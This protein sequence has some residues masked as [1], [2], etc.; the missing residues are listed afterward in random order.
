MSF[1]RYPGGKS[2]LKKE[3]VGSLTF[4][5]K[6]YLTRYCEPFWG[7]GS[8]GMAFIFA[9][10]DISNVWINDKDI[11][12]ASLWTAV[13]RYSKDLEKLVREFKPSIDKFYEFKKILLEIS[14]MPTNPKEIL[15]IGFQKLAIHQI[16]YSG[17]GTKSGSPLGGNKQKSNYKIDCRWSPNYI[18]KNI[19]K[20]NYKLNSIK[21]HRDCCTNLDFEEVINNNE[22]QSLLYLDPPYYKQGNNL[23][24]EGF[25]ETQHQKL[26][27]ILQQTKHSWILSY[28]DCEEIERLYN[29]AYVRKIDVSYT[30]N[31]EGGEGKSIKNKK[32]LLILPKEGKIV[33]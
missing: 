31:T 27:D 15:Q 7:G 2:K 4:Q 23:Y 17:L 18:C 20:I 29:W 13:I 3:I 10:P 22:H 28:D 26:A 32:E 6:P 14:E 5:K 21:I 12:I 11:G 30:I 24:Q 1:F 8:I 9:D 16:S 19:S 33:L 25:T